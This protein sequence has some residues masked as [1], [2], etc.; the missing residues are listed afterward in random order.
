MPLLLCSPPSLLQ[1]GLGGHHLLFTAPSTV[2]SLPL[3]CLRHDVDAIVWQPLATND[4]VTWN[5]LGTF[6]ALG[7][8]Q[9]AK[10]DKKFATCPPSLSFT[11]ISDCNRHV[12]VYRQ[13]AEGVKGNTALQYVHTID[14]GAEILGLQTSGRGLA[15]V[16]C[17]KEVLVL[18]VK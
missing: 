13:P 11:A 3:F 18:L 1:V 8:V 5:H 17:E 15:F 4:E 6:N 10:M 9:A 2:G 7:Y 12:F 16:L 14:S